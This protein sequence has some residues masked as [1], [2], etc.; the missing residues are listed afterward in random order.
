LV[1]GLEPPLPEAQSVITQDAALKAFGNLTGLT[2]Q[3]F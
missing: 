2:S 1:G 3:V